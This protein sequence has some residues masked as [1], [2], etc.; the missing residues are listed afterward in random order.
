[1]TTDDEIAPSEALRGCIGRC[2]AIRL[3]IDADELDSAQDELARL[4]RTLE[5]VGDMFH[6]VS[7][8]EGDLHRAQ[9]ECVS[10]VRLMA[11]P[12]ASE[13]SLVAIE[14]VVAGVLGRIGA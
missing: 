14:R 6:G 8:I 7:T 4:R 12:L 3:L 13:L 10:C 11:Y 2:S 5:W 9:R 1:M